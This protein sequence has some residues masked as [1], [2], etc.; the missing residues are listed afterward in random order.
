[1]NS[2]ALVALGKK[3]VVELESERPNTLARWMAH[4]IAQLIHEAEMASAGEKVQKMAVC[5]DAILRLWK[6]IHNFPPGLGPFEDFEPILRALQS[7][8]PE[9]ET[10]RYLAMWPHQ[11]KVPA[12][13][14]EAQKPLRVLAGVD[15]AARMIIRMYLLQAAERAIDKSRDWVKL[16]TQ[17][18]LDQEGMVLIVRA[19]VDEQE[20]LTG[21][22]ED[23]VKR[24]MLEDRIKRLDDFIASAVDL[25]AALKQHLAD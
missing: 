22:R 20:R 16:A 14:T 15:Q 11:S 19:I 10:P 7:L 3:I 18:G 4:Y 24:K 21:A 12:D 25:S 1:V 6:D 8:D 23:E 2:D 9:K 17:A 13:E 5:A